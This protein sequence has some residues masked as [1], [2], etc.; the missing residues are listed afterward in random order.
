MGDNSSVAYPFATAE[1]GLNTC[2]GKGITPSDF[3]YT[4]QGRYR[5]S[6]ATECLSFP[7]HY[8]YYNTFGAVCQVFF[9]NFEDFILQSYRRQ[10]V[11]QVRKTLEQNRKQIPL[12]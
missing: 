8:N 12:H 1:R 10:K 2:G 6:L 11:L 5:K 7:F 3:S 9:D 4:S